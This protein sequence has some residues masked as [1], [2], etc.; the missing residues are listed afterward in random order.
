MEVEA[1]LLHKG[2]SPL[3]FVLHYYLPEIVSL[4]RPHETLNAAS[5]LKTAIETFDAL[6][7]PSSFSL[8]KGSSCQGGSKWQADEGDFPGA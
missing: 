6:L 1:D 8:P 7:G 2:A 3:T 4:F 5:A